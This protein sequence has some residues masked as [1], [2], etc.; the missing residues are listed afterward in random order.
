[1]E[2]F[3]TSLWDYFAPLLVSICLAYGFQK[4]LKIKLDLAYAIGY[5]IFALVIYGL[6]LCGFTITASYA[7]F[8]GVFTLAI[9]VFGLK[10]RLAHNIEKRDI[11]VTIAF[12]ILYTAVFFFDLN[13]GFTHWDEMSHWGPMVKENLR[14]NQLYLVEESRLQAHKDYP[15][16]IA[17][18]ETAWSDL[19]GGY[20]EKYLYRGLHM[21]ISAMIF[22]MITHFLQLK[23]RISVMNSVFVAVPFITVCTVL[24]L[25][26]GNLLTTIYAD[27]ALA[28]TAAF[29]VFLIITLR[30]YKKSENVILIIALS[31]L[32]LVKQIGFEYFCLCYLLLTLMGILDYKACI[33]KRCIFIKNIL[34]FIIPVAF[35]ISWNIY[36]KVN[37]ISGQFT[38]SKFD[39]NIFKSVVMRTDINTW[40]Y[41]G[42]IGFFN[43]LFTKP[44]IIIRGYAVSYADLFAIYVIVYFFLFLLQKRAKKDFCVFPLFV[45]Y[46]ISAVGH[47]MMMWISYMFL[48]CESDFTE[49][50]CWERYMNVIWI[51]NGIVL[52]FLFLEIFFEVINKK[53]FVGFM[54]AVAAISVGVIFLSDT[55]EFLRPAL[56]NNSSLKE[57]YEEADF[58][59]ENTNEESSIFIVTQS[60]TGYFEYVFQY[61][62][63]PRSYNN[64][65]YSLGKPYSEEDNWTRDISI[66]DFLSIIDEYD[67]IY[68]WKV[69]EQFIEEYGS[70]LNNANDV[71]FEN[72]YLYYIENSGNGNIDL[73]LRGTFTR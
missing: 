14:L 46:I 4:L 54:G 17:L 65:Y 22:P 3:M 71:I 39:M 11:E 24:S 64:T 50:A 60:H 18:I 31:F 56:Q 36:V 61:L 26:D 69:D 10:G 28:V 72:G 47:V 59:C 21:L 13:R 67:Y 68:F 35:R 57:Y 12:I 53:L 51:F 1:M 49:L 52:V 23:N 40:Q 62:T 37:H 41:K 29:C 2:I 55:E 42:T 63:M 16:V 15:P 27:G 34:L 33:D 66:E 38:L 25:D 30:E 45:T 44:L 9:M 6:I 8:W 5:M 19:C 70:A 48:Y 20:S 43:A 7:V 73:N 32:L 58:I